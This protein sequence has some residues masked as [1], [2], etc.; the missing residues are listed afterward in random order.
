M[1]KCIKAA[2]NITHIVNNDLSMK[3]DQEYIKFTLAIISLSI[4][5]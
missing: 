5:L 2:I 3:F 4:H 1:L